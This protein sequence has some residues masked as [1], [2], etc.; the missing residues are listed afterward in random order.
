MVS[1]VTVSSLN[2]RSPPARDLPQPLH[3]FNVIGKI[4]IQQQYGKHQP[5][6]FLVSCLSQIMMYSYDM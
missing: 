4:L 6:R 1:D 3:I 2:K 5:E